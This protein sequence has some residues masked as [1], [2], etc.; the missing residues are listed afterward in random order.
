MLDTV[1]LRSD[2]ERKEAPWWQ[3]VR[4]TAGALSLKILMHTILLL[5][6]L[7]VRMEPL[8][9]LR[10][11]VAGLAKG[12]SARGPCCAAADPARAGC[13]RPEMALL[14]AT[15]QQVAESGQRVLQSHQQGRKG[16]DAAI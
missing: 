4:L 14:E 5:L 15:M 11:T 8:L 7:K 2:L 10:S 12:M 16:A 1:H 13:G 3:E 6:L 9:S